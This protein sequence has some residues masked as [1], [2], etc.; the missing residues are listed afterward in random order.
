MR[1]SS[2]S[3][4]ANFAPKQ[5]QLH[6]RKQSDRARSRLWRK[7]GRRC[8][9]RPVRCTRVDSVVSIF[10]FTSLINDRTRNNRASG[11][12][13]CCDAFSDDPSR[14]SLRQSR[15]HVR[16][17]ALTDFLRVS[18]YE[19]LFIA[20]PLPPSSSP[21][22]GQTRLPA[23]FVEISLKRPNERETRRGE[24]RVVNFTVVADGRA[25]FACRESRSSPV[26]I[27]CLVKCVASYARM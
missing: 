3:I 27:S 23:P 20:L 15:R 24:I 11:G 13:G 2:I 17:C 18:S 21:F 22:L 1:V 6:A 9:K 8:Y 16:A 10:S 4:L 19:R 25:R 7:L 14:T 12:T 5:R 26:W